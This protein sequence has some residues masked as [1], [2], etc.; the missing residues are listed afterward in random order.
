MEIESSIR[1]P[2]EWPDCVK[3]ALVHVASMAHWAIIYTKSWC[4]NSPIARVRMAGQL[5]QTKQENSLLGE[6]IRIKDARMAKI[7]AKNR[8]H[9]PPTERMAILELKAARGWSAAQ[10]ADVFNLDPETVADWL[11]RTHD[12]DDD[13]LQIPTPINKFPQF[14][15]HVVCRLKVL[16]PAM[17]KERIAQTLA[18]AGL[19]L[20]ATTVGRCL[21]SRRPVPPSDP[22]VE[23]PSGTRTVTA[24]YVDHVWHVDLT[25][26]PTTTGFWTSWFPWSSPTVWPFCWHVALVIDH[27]SR[28]VMAFS[29]FKQPPTSAALRQFLGA[30][31]KCHR[32]RPGHIVSDRGKQ[33]H[34]A[35]YQRWCKRRKIQY[36]YGAVG[37]Y[38]S[39]ALIERFIR[40]MKTE[41]TRI[42]L[43]PCGCDD[44]RAELRCY[45]TW[46]NQFRPHQALG[47]RTPT[48]VYEN[49]DPLSG[50]PLPNSK[51]PRRELQVAYFE[52][53]KH[54]PVVELREAA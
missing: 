26:V 4:A 50:N 29:L 37:K 54:L 12:P 30:A 8:P 18:R 17:G 20:S 16:C 6:E 31:M 13:L 21:S 33:F 35:E 46:Y 22:V 2:N 24:K 25:T 9:Y 40:T 7:P 14:V 36:R 49:H 1:V 23:T 42:I 15:R 27:Y 34:C 10:T 5:D 41:C 11:R 32:T 28:R 19:L 47:G 44:M 52:G 39:I 43:V 45:T 3:A 51:L 38:G 53:R 48:D